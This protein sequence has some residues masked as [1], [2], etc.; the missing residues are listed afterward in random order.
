MI[1]GSITMALLLVTLSIALYNS[2]GA[3]Q[4]DLSRPGYQE[5]RG[6]AQQPN[7]LDEFSATGEL[8]SSTLKQFDEL[9]RKQQDDILSDK[10]GF[11]PSQLNNENLG[12]RV[13]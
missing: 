11:N 12:V 6:R 10:S 8:N 2:S 9:Y 3:A 4:L 7:K 13:D 5:V 1:A